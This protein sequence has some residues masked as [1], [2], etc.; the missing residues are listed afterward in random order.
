MKD[1]AVKP[2]NALVVSSNMASYVD[3]FLLSQDI[4][5]NSKRTYRHGLMQFME[6]IK[7]GGTNEPT[8]EDVLRY[9]GH[10]IN[11]GLSP[12]TLSTYLVAVRKFFEWA[13]SMKYYPNI[14][15]GIKGAKRLRGFRKDCLT[16]PQAKTLL[17]GIDISTLEGKRNHALLNLMIRTGLRTIEIKRADVGDIRQE[18][19]KAVLYIQGK[20]RDTKDE[21]VLLTE[22]TL[23]PINEYLQAREHTEDKDPLFTSLSDRNFNQRL[24][25]RTISRIAKNHLRGI[26][27]DNLRFSAHSLRHSAITFSLQGG[28]T[29]QQAQTLGRHANIN[30]TLTYSHNIN[31]I[32]NAPEKFIDKLLAEKS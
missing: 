26:G 28:A 31:R 27:L 30:T 2:D 3:K 18:S 16:V 20:G 25:T 10:L 13:E 1:T 8:R 11:R 32:A 29:I 6:W 21:L 17:N 23:N 24:T 12:L 5:D 19:G 15:R 4:Q 7:R 22:E 9:K 14:A